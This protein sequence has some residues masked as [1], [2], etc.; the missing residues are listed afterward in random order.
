MKRVLLAVATL[1]T[2]SSA[3]GC[4]LKQ[5]DSM[6]VEWE[7]YKSLGKIG[8]AGRFTDVAY[9]PIAL[10]GKNFASLLVGSKVSID[11]TKIDTGNP[12]RDETLVKFFFGKM[13][14]TIEATIKDIKADKRIKGRPRTGSLEVMIKMNERSLII[15]MNYN[16]DKEK[17]KA[18]GV[19]DLSDFGAEDALSSINKSC[20]ELHKGKTWSDVTIG[21]ETNIKATLCDVNITR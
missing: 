11:T 15:P 20:Y 1:Y 4:L 8:V 5:P 6:G 9:T 16:Y 14:G 2:L 17:F 13:S 19:I 7:A 18:Q 21:F 3:G 12:A 10:E